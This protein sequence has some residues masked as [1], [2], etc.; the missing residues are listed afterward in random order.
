MGARGAGK[1]TAAKALTERGWVPQAFGSGIYE[2]C[3]AAFTVSKDLF[4]RRETKETPLDA[5]MLA[6]CLDQDFVAVALQ[7]LDATVPPGVDPMQAPRSPRFIMQTWGTEYR[8]GQLGESYWVDQVHD[9]ML[10]LPGSDFALTDVREHIEIALVRSYGGPLIRIR[11][12]TAVV[13]DKTTMSHTS[14]TSVANVRADLELFNPDGQE[15]IARLHDQ[16]RN[17]VANWYSMNTAA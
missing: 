5:L 8:R 11:K 6:T 14:E 9:R 7:R 13:T 15:N 12:P 4:G 17:F 16:V 10:G 1:D 3:A 2:E